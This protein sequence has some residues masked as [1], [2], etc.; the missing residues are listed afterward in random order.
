MNARIAAGMKLQDDAIAAVSAAGLGIV[1]SLV[2]MLVRSGEI[3]SICEQG[4]GREE[5]RTLRRL[6][7]EQT[8]SCAGGTLEVSCFASARFPPFPLKSLAWRKSPVAFR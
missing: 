8:T 3:T 5:G 2:P 4:V 7:P 6:L 1:A